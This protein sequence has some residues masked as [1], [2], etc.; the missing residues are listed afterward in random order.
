MTKEQA[1]L[2]T[3]TVKSLGIKII[4]LVLDDNYN[5]IYSLKWHSD[6]Y[7]FI[8]TK[9]TDGYMHTL[10]VSDFTFMEC[11]KLFNWNESRDYY[12][13]LYSWETA[14]LIGNKFNNYQ[15]WPFLD[16]SLHYPEYNPFRNS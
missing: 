8:Y 15:G 7:G 10:E 11:I 9:G 12:N 4:E 13:A 3:T 5:N 1:N 2:F 16:Q 14:L 6:D